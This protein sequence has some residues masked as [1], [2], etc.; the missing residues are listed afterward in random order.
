[1]CGCERVAHTPAGVRAVVGGVRGSELPLFR[2]APSAQRGG[3]ARRC[4]GVRRG[5][6]G[7]GGCR[8]GC[9]SSSRMGGS[10][11][12]TSGSATLIDDAYNANPDSVLAS[13]RALVD[14]TP[15]SISAGAGGGGARG[16]LGRRKPRP[17]GCAGGS[18]AE[19][20]QDRRAARRVAAVGAQAARPIAEGFAEGRGAEAAVDGR[21]GLRRRE[22]CARSSGWGAR[23]RRARQGVAAG[24][25]SNGSSGR[26]RKY[27]A[28]VGKA[29]GDVQ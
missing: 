23:G 15:R 28:T 3:G 4:A 25:G 29:A 24:S 10:A 12:L 13:A 17:S 14:A 16:G 27:C 2:D 21:A 6:P 8:H 26:S 5:R 7:R 1:M 22:R 20:A 19:L 9:V 11:C 18:A